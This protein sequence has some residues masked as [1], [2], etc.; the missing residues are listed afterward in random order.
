MLRRLRTPVL[1]SSGLAIALSIATFGFGAANAASGRPAVGMACTP[2][3]DRDAGISQRLGNKLCRVE[4]RI[5]TS[6]SE[7]DAV[8]GAYAAVGVQV[9]PLAG[10]D[11]RDRGLPSSAEAQNL[12]SWAA[13]FGPS[14]TFWQGKS[15]PVPITN[16]EFGNETS[17]S[18]QSSDNSTGAYAG[19]AQTYALRAKE[20]AQSLSG[21]GVG[22]LIQLD[23]ADGWPWVSNMKAAVP[24]LDRYAA[25]W[26]VHPYG[27]SG[28]SKVQRVLSQAASAGWSS[29]IPLFFTEWGLATDNGRTLSDNYGFS[30]SMTYSDAAATVRA[31]MAAWNSAFGSRLSEVIYYMITDLR[32]SG[33][34]GEREDYFGAVKLDGSDKGALT[35]ELRNWFGGSAPTPAPA[36]APTPAPAPAPTPAPAPAPTPAPAPAPTPAPAPKPAPT[37]APAPKPAPTPAPAPKPAPTPA[38]APAKAATPATGAATTP[39]ATT[40]AVTTPA[41][42]SPRTSNRK[43]ST[44]RKANGW[45][46]STLAVPG[47]YTIEWDGRIFGSAGL[48]RSYVTARGIDWSDFLVKHPAVAEQAAL[49][50]VAWN[51]KVFYD[52]ASLAHELAKLK[53]PYRKW[54]T[55]HPTAAAILAGRMVASA[56]ARPAR[57][58]ATPAVTWDSIGFTSAQGLRIYMNQRNRNWNAFLS[59]HPKIVQ[60]LKLASVSLDETLFYSRQ[61]LSGWLTSHNTTLAK[62]S[63]NHPG[64]AEKLMP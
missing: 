58:V 11:L 47:A 10:F 53:V 3:V 15:N 6:A 5:T 29:D 24:D 30:P 41:S 25:G 16:I 39:S 31:T 64:A 33:A 27:T 61:A 8:I 57:V 23:D 26:T 1:I 17:Y 38:S 14:G 50:S 7:M 43:S 44:K 54:A 22:L 12:R 20:A 51:K 32:E 46:Q 36:P 40:P 18:Y 60:Q 59:T 42:P 56:E 45:G 48:L 9:Q 4:F 13:R 52:Q 63:A 21:T 55:S 2:W 37:P 34:S 49:P 62:W 19:R 35:T 28:L